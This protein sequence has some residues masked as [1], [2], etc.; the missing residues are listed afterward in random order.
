MNFTKASQITIMAGMSLLAAAARLPASTITYSTNV[1]GT[2]FGGTSL[3]LNSSGG[4]AATLTFTPNANAMSGV[5]SNIN[6]GLFTLA[7]PTCS[8]QTIGT[9]SMFSAFMFDLLITDV[10]DGATGRFVG[11]STGGPVYSD[12]SQITINWAPLQLGPGTN[13]ALI[14]DFGLTIFSTRVFTGIVAPNSGADRGQTTVE[15]FVDFTNSA[16]VPEPATNFLVGG[17]LCL[18][19]MLR[20]QY[21]RV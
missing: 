7:C 9:S 14:G 13:N 4:Q 2:G 15:G 20:L 12:A 8:T 11:T 3:I 16:T 6:L 19:G 1:A 5:P 21:R 10:T 17:A 18:L